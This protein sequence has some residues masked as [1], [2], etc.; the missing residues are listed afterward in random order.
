[1][2]KTGQIGLVF[3]FHNTFYPRKEHITCRDQREFHTY[4]LNALL[5][6]TVHSKALHIISKATDQIKAFPENK[7][8]P[9]YTRRIR[10]LVEMR[11]GKVLIR[12][13]LNV[14]HLSFLANLGSDCTF[15]SVS[16]CPSEQLNGQD[17]FDSRHIAHWTNVSFCNTTQPGPHII[18]LGI[19]LCDDYYIE[20]RE[21]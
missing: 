13:Y 16:W 19:D 5:T 1:M 4:V 17:S 15:N 9:T 18:F 7:Q 11:G 21:Q 20:G 12:F 3:A 2:L 10:M 8:T 6:H 14:K